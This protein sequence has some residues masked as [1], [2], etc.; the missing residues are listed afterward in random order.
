M[1]KRLEKK[2]MLGRP[3]RLG[4]LVVFPAKK[5]SG[6]IEL[7]WGVVRELAKDGVRVSRGAGMN[8]RHLLQRLDR[9]AVVYYAHQRDTIRQFVEA[10]GF[11][12]VTTH[13][14]QST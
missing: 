2:D 1:S 8:R 12:Y 14:P 7:H 13:P 11:D 9:V 4:D 5:K 3:I 10:Q 6:P